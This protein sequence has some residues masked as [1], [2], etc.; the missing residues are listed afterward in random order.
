MISQERKK[1]MVESLKEDYVVLTDLVVEVVADTYADMHVLKWENQQPP[2][3][4]QDKKH[5]MGLKETYSSLYKTEPEKAVD[6]IEQIYEISE[7]YNKLR[8]EKGL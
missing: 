1:Q 7:K 6:I 8:M 5:L 4:E 3:L 2:E